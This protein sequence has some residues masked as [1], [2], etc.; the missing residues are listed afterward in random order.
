M[1]RSRSKGRI[2]ET[3]FVSNL[4]ST[5]DLDEVDRLANHPMLRPS[6]ARETYTLGNRRGTQNRY[7]QP[8]RSSMR[9]SRSEMGGYASDTGGGFSAALSQPMLDRSNAA[10]CQSSTNMNQNESQSM[11]TY[12]PPAE[13]GCRTVAVGMMRGNGARVLRGNLS[14]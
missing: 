4:S 13:F 9:K 14:R 8:F 11:T 3:A 2:L 7:W 10:S 6:P 1:N 5:E 12:P